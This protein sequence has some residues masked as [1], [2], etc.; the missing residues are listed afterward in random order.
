MMSHMISAEALLAQAKLMESYGA[1]GIT[2]MD[3]AGAY[4]PDEVREKVGTLVAGLSVPVG[5]HSHN[6]LG[7]AVANALAAVEA[8]ATIIDGTA[9]GLGAGAGNCPLEPV[10]AVLHK[11]GYQTGLSLYPLMDGG[12]IVQEYAGK[13]PEITTVTLASGIAGVFSGFAPHA[14]KAAAQYGVDVR[15]IL[16]EL[17]KRK[18][19][20]GQEDMI[21]EIAQQLKQKQEGK[22]KDFQL[23]SLT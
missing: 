10:V 13:L 19:V 11:K 2:L 1:Q 23:E 12:D 20:A 16:W 15:D 9:R 8:G 3:S 5:F 21:I 18:V 22:P 7:L 14:V 6:N 4:I 17:G